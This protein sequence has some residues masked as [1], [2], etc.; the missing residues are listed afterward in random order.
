MALEH[1]I[2]TALAEQPGTG[3]ELAR[4]FDK[5]IGQFWSA[6]HQQ[7]YRTLARMEADGWVTSTEIAQHGR[8]DKKVYRLTPAGRAALAAWVREPADLDV[9]RSELAVK[10]RAATSRELPSLRA[11]IARHREQRQLR[12]DAYLANEKREFANPAELRGRRLNQYLVLRGGIAVEQTLLG[13]LD[14]VLAA[15]PGGA[16]SGGR[17]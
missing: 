6:T 9:P 11:E 7:I 17:R 5:S 8:P 12:L 14:E 15:L 16:R 13:W 4:R 1:A 3:Y 10:L 2:A